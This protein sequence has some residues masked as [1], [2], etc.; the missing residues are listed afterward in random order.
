[1]EGNETF[2][3][4]ENMDR[5]L[6]SFKPVPYP[7]RILDWFLSMM[8]SLIFIISLAAVDLIALFSF[9]INKYVN[10]GS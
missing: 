7:L 1:M 8:I 3:D 6:S 4:R 9:K 2:G 5:Y 10:R